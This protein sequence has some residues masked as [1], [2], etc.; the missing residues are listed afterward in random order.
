MTHLAGTI[1]PVAMFD[2][3]L[4]KEAA[5]AADPKALHLF[6]QNQMT[7]SQSPAPNSGYH[8]AHRTN[9]E[10]K[11][12]KLDQKLK[13]P[14]P[15]ESQSFL[16]RGSASNGSSNSTIWLASSISKL[17]I[18]EPLLIEKEKPK[19]D[20]TET[21]PAIAWDLTILAD[22]IAI[23]DQK[24]TTFFLNRYLGQNKTQ[25]AVD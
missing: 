16:A 22:V 10:A 23:H 1:E 19:A 11:E 18:D 9:S 3:E 7:T 12:P 25:A 8:C 2:F 13:W 14:L 17:I 4:R 6:F 20:S 21:G 24:F 15:L 5:K